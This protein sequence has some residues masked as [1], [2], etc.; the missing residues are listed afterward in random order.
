[1]ANQEAR[2]LELQGVAAAE[3]GKFDEAI[4]IFTASIDVAPEHASS[5][6]NRAQAFR[7]KGNIAG[8]K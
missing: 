2:T 4:K 3:A 5:Y 1:V 7:L 8:I 6:N